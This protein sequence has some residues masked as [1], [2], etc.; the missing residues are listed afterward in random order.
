MK[1]T[2]IPADTTPEAAR[3]QREIFRKMPA[4]ARLQLA[5]QMSDT[6]RGIVADGIRSRHPTFSDEQIRLEV[7]RTYLGEEAFRMASGRAQQS[8]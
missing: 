7:I 8:P 5:L 2:A 4:V 1:L 3:V 6:L